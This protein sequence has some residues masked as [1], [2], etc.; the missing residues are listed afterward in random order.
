MTTALQAP[1]VPINGNFF[2]LSKE[3]SLTF[4]I[5]EIEDHLV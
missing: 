5:N 3:K 4:F 2:L 1:H